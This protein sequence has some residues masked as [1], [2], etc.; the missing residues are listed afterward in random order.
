MP[1]TPETTTTTPGYFTKELWKDWAV[2]PNLIT[3]IRF[4]LSPLPFML[5]IWP[6]NQSH[7]FS[8]AVAFVLVTSTDKIDGFLARRLNLITELGTLIDPVVDKALVV[9]TLVALSIVHPI[10]WIPSL[11]ILIREGLVGAFL[12]RARNRGQDVRVLP[13]GKI[14]TVAQLVAITLMFVPASGLWLLLVWAIIVGTVILTIA[15]GI[16]YYFVFREADDRKE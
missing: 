7:W 10:M 16:E 3:E 15:S 14:K 1:N 5:L 9:L 6:G 13:S 4:L 11:I 8:A 12:D 2:L